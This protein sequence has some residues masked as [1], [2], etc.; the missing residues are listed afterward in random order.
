MGNDGMGNGELSQAARRLRRWREHD[1]AGF[2]VEVVDAVALQGG[3]EEPDFRPLV[4]EQFLHRLAPLGQSFCGEFRATIEMHFAEVEQKGRRNDRHFND[5][6]LIVEIHKLGD[7]E[8]AQFSHLGRLKT[9]ITFPLKQI[10]M[11]SFENLHGRVVVCRPN[12]AVNT[13]PQRAVKV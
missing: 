9:L 3:E 12:A 2:G 1:I 5:E 10:I 13:R 11:L 6:K 7:R 8:S 4:L